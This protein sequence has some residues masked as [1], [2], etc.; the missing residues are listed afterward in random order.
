MTD[1]PGWSSGPGG[2]SEPLPSEPTS[3]PGETPAAGGAPQSPTPPYGSP[4][5]S[6]PSAGSY[7]PSVPPPD[8]E[9]RPELMIDHPQHL[10]RLAVFFRWLIL[11]PHYF[12][13]YFLSIAASVV[14]VI[15]W[16]G[17]LFL[18]HLP[19]WAGEFLA[20]FVE[21]YTRVDASSQLLTDRYPPFGF[22]PSGA[23]A[24]IEL[25][26]PDRLNRAAVFFRFILAI[27]AAIVAAATYLGWFVAAFFIWIIV[28][29]LGR[30]PAPLFEATAAVVRYRL[31]YTAYYYLLTSAY[32]KK[33]F[34]DGDGDGEPAESA[35]AAAAEPT[36]ETAYGEPVASESAHAA[37][38]A[39]PAGTRPLLLSGGARALLV[40]FIVLGALYYVGA[41]AG[42]AVSAAVSGP[43]AAVAD[44]QTTSAYN[45]YLSNVR[46]AGQALPSCSSRSCVTGQFGKIRDSARAL[47]GRVADI[48]Y[49]SSTGSA[50]Q[51]LRSDL[52]RVESAAGELTNV[53]S[54]LELQAKLASTKF[55]QH[56]NAVDSDAHHLDSQLR[57]AG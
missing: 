22:W 39:T 12:V 1:T 40:L 21:W 7:P 27:P 51:K 28:L 20:G 23:E 42:G 29:V 30:M 25:P 48:D 41:V 43:S 13:L 15:G 18:G 24:R 6:D 2:P 8:A 19:R 46:S 52:T 9:P 56:L 57:A 10:R 47:R 26:A 37:P 54:P 33:L 35:P 45:N 16:F 53:Q 36:G 50:A 17:A 5:P 49:P 31:R 38:A 32:P 4:P 3:R 34:G 44:R 11:I 55:Q 14:V